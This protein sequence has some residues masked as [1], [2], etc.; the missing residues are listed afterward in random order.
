M[1]HLRIF[2]VLVSVLCW[3]IVVASILLQNLFSHPL[4]DV[5]SLVLLVLVS[6]FAGLVIL[7]LRYV[8]IG[9]F[10]SLILSVLVVL[11]VLVLPLYLGLVP[12]LTLGED[13]YAGAIVMIFRA[14]FP[15]I[16][17]LTLLASSIGA[18]IGDRIG[19]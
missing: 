1:S 14:Y 5:T 15:N 4:V 12:H 7:D 11:L 19:I 18:M 6:F 3:G 10:A 2:R 13:L 17:V 16:V 9:W 8:V